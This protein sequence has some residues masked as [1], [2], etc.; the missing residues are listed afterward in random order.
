MFLKT[1]FSVRYATRNTYVRIGGLAMH[2]AAGDGNLI[3]VTNVSRCRFE[4][5]LYQITYHV[6]WKDESNSCDGYNVNLS[7]TNSDKSM[8]PLVHLDVNYTQA[9]QC[10]KTI[11]P[12]SL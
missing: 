3:N 5:R 6:F 4:W 8:T 12:K 11:C 1:T 10:N 2:M 9:Y 7:S